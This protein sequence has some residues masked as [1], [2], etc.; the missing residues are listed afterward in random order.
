MSEPEFYSVTQ[1][2]TALG[3]SREGVLKRLRRGDLQ[4]IH[5][6]SQLWLISKAE[7]ERAAAE[8]RLKPGPKRKPPA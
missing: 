3:L 7:V 1:A 4:G 6:H 5:P 8:G 2:A